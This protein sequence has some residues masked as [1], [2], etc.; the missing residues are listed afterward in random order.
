MGDDKR[1]SVEQAR[2]LDVA[3]GACSLGAALVHGGLVSEH[4]A[5]WWG[6]GAF[7]VV[8]SLAQTLLALALFVD[9]F[10][11]ARLRVSK[12]SADRALRVAG[13]VGQSLLVLLYAYTRVVGVPLAGPAQGEVEGIAPVDL[14]AEALQL[15]CIVLL[16]AR[17]RTLR[18]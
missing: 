11:P 16:G 1:A 17:L 14:V 3:A 5:Q 6:Y 2:S 15:A 9:P 12:G 7:F 13:I 10:D 18:G 4:Y 8:A